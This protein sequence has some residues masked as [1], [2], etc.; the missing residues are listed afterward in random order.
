MHV[1]ELH[2]RGAQRKQLLP[3]CDEPLVVQMS[4]EFVRGLLA[5]ISP[6]GYNLSTLD[7][8]EVS[9]EDHRVLPPSIAA[10]GGRTPLNRGS[11][12]AALGVVRGGREGLL[13]VPRHG[14]AVVL[15]PARRRM[16]I[17]DVWLR[18]RLIKMVRG[19]A[20]HAPLDEG[21]AQDGG[22]WWTLAPVDELFDKL[23]RLALRHAVRSERKHFSATDDVVVLAKLHAVDPLGRAAKGGFIPEDG[24]LECTARRIVRR[25][26]ERLLGWWS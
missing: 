4:A 21:G 15:Q 22:G 16:L 14:H 1:E 10:D 9:A 19:E 6:K 2:H 24:A 8:T 13:T 5:P 3:L 20:K 7:R 26:G 12:G 11:E 18:Q 25:I 17:G 23:A